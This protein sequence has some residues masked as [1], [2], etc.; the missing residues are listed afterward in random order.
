MILAKQG[1]NLKLFKKI[2]DFIRNILYGNGQNIECQDYKDNR[3]QQ[4]CGYKHT[5][6]KRDHHKCNKSQNARSIGGKRF[7][8]VQKISCGIKNQ[9]CQNKQFE[10]VAAFQPA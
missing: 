10:L 1:R 8:S 9:R 3:N 6:Q 7:A 5:R 4:N 2:Q